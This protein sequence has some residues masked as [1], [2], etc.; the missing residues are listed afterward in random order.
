MIVYWGIL[1]NKD[2]LVV[3]RPRALKIPRGLL[4]RRAILYIGGGLPKALPAHIA[5]KARLFLGA[6]G[7]PPMLLTYSNT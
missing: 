3:T 6:L 5:C 4:P 1:L 2:L 7:L